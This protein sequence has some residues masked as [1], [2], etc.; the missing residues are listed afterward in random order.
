MFFFTIP[1]IAF[2]VFVGAVMIPYGYL[3]WHFEFMPKRRFWH[4]DRQGAEA[5]TIGKQTMG[6]G[7]VAIGCI[8]VVLI[9]SL[10]LNGV[11]EIE[12]VIRRKF[13]PVEEKYSKEKIRLQQEQRQ[14]AQEKSS[15]QVDKFQEEAWDRMYRSME[16]ATN[17]F[18]EHDRLRQEENQ[19]S[20]D[21]IQN[22]FEEM[23]RKIQ[24]QRDQLNKPRD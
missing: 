8:P 17:Q 3:V 10:F 13:N 19:K 23:K 6:I 20:R 1:L 14:A 18:D 12:F 24:E 11:F 9:L 15:E 7:F 21:K 5:K 22:E 16:S 4:R 2:F